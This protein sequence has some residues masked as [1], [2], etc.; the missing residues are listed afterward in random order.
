MK[1][2]LIL[3]T[4]ILFTSIAYSDNCTVTKVLSGDTIVC[5]LENKPTEIRLLG[6]QSPAKTDSDK[7]CFADK[8]TKCLEDLVLNKE[9]RLDYDGE[10]KRFDKSNGLL[11]WIFIGNENIN[12]ELIKKGCS[13]VYNV[14]PYKK[15]PVLDLIDLNLTAAE[16]KAG[17]WGGC[18]N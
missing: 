18:G 6:V 7:H 13:R 4:L 8:S 9:V 1:I 5:N 14:I 10:E 12:L 11:A 2:L 3:I 16:Q 15:Y 17:F